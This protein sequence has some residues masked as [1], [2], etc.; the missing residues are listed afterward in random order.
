VKLLVCNTISLTTP[1]PFAEDIQLC[2]RN[3]MPVLYN[4]LENREM[5]LEDGRWVVYVFFGP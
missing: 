5:Q 1:A 2:E 3:V 4:L